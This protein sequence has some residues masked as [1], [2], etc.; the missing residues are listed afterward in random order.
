MAK[1]EITRENY[2]RI[3]QTLCGEKIMSICMDDDKDLPVMCVIKSKFYCFTTDGTYTI[4]RPKYQLD[5]SP[6]SEPEPMH[7][8]QAAMGWFVDVNANAKKLM[9]KGKEANNLQS[10]TIGVATEQIS[11]EAIKFL[12]ELFTARVGETIKP[13]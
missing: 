1:P 10:F 13:L 12:T 11:G 5:L 7:V 2:H 9:A 6:L 4:T 3:K 8:A